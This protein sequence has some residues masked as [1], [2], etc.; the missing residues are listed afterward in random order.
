MPRK[1]NGRRDVAMQPTCFRS[2]GQH[3]YRSTIEQHGRLKIKM[4][5]FQGF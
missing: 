3:E 2:V 5:K 1:D 4:P